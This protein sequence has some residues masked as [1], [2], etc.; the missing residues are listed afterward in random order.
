MTA[1][2]YDLPHRALIQAGRR[3]GIAVSGDA[4]HAPTRL[5][6]PGTLWERI[7]EGKRA[8]GTPDNF[9]NRQNA[10]HAFVKVRRESGDRG[11]PAATA[12]SRGAGIIRA[13]KRVK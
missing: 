12:H 13:G 2:V 7:A 10:A 6:R 1:T 3:I 8:S 9:I 5:Q 4:P 11:W